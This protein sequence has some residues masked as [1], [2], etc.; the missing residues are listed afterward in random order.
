M[1]TTTRLFDAAKAAMKEL[2]ER[3]NDEPRCD[4]LSTIEIAYGGEEKIVGPFDTL[5]EAKAG[6]VAFS[7]F[8]G[9]LLV[10]PD[11]GTVR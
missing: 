4:P 10:M 3:M 6:A 2:R 9:D 8:V 11:K 7:N 5:E 1:T